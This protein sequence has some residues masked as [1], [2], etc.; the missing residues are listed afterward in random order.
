MLNIKATKLEK[1]I[2]VITIM[3]TSMLGIFISDIYVPSLPSISRDFGTSESLLAF[4]VTLYFFTYALAQLIY[5]PLSERFG[6]RRIFLSGM[7][8]SLFGTIITLSSINFTML[9]I[10]RSIEAIGMAAPMSLGRV[11]FRDVIHDKTQ[12]ARFMSFLGI[13]TL[14]APVIAPIVGAFLAKLFGWRADFVFI[15][16][17]SISCYI[18]ALFY[19]KET[20]LSPRKRLS[21]KLTLKTYLWV[22]R[23]RSFVKNMLISS[24]IMSAIISYFS[25]SP[26]L[27]EQHFGLSELDYAT[28]FAT[29]EIFLVFGMFSNGL[30][31]KTISIE[32]SQRLSV[33]LFVIAVIIIN[34]D[35]F[36]ASHNLVLLMG[37]IML[38]NYAA[39]MNFPTSSTLAITAFKTRLGAVGSLYGCL[40]MLIAGCVGGLATL[41]D[42]PADAAVTLLFSLM[43][44]ICLST[45]IVLRKH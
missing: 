17:L 19:L 7:T 29:G 8:I 26:F 27:F 28:V 5:G 10:G 13:G 2:F 23:N 39:G 37:G 40:S 32:Q 15:F 6:R 24:T 14:M 22:I 31:L 41:S 3:S 18:A 9:L 20:L 42:F 25:L 43:A 44:L 35:Y 11:I 4:S 34:I 38:F 16:I 36:F 45:L 21:A 33:S 12:Y 1:T 30:L